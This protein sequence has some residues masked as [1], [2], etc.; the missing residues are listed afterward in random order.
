MNTE[1]DMREFMRI[2]MGRLLRFFFGA[3]LRAS[4]RC[5]VYRV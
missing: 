1:T 4:A 2:D 3:V 5:R